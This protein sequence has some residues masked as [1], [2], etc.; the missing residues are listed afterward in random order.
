[1]RNVS[2]PSVARLGRNNTLVC[3]SRFLKARTQDP[4][5]RI[6]LTV[7]PIYTEY[8]QLCVK[9]FYT[10][11]VVCVCVHTIHVCMYMD[12]CARIYM[13]ICMCIRINKQTNTCVYIYILCM[14]GNSGNAY[15]YIDR[16]RER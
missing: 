3:P 16:E 2:L 1:M 5:L 4:L 8:L 11:S 9:V 14:G 13:Y 10:L 7:G 12:I 15:I 6:L